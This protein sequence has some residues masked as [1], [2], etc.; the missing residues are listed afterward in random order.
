MHMYK[1]HCVYKR[2]YVP[3]GNFYIGYH[4]GAVLTMSTAGQVSNNISVF[5]DGYEGSGG[6]AGT[7][8]RC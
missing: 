8:R 7:F 2:E 6:W 4:Y 3:S 5:E 1:K